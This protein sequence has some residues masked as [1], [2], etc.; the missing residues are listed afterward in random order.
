V[1]RLGRAAFGPEGRPAERLR[2]RAADTDAEKL[3]P[4][5]LWY[6]TDKE[7]LALESITVDGRRLRYSRK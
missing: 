1:E 5:E 4:I 7:W 3:R 2:L 6:S